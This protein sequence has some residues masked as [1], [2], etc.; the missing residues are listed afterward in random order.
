MEVIHGCPLLTDGKKHFA[1]L[2]T[3]DGVHIGHEKIIRTMVADA[4]GER[5]KSL[6]ITFSNHPRNFLK[7]EKPIKLLTSAMAKQKYIGRLGV[8]L[9]ALLEF[10]RRLADMDP[11]TFVRDI[12]VSCYK[13]SHIYV[14][15][16]YTFGFK[17]EGT[18]QLLKEFGEMF[19]FKV[20]VMPPIC[21]RGDP[22]SSSSIRG[23][24]ASGQIE[25]ASEY[26]GRFPEFTAEV[27]HG[28]KIGR[29]IGFPTANLL[30]ESD[31]QLPLPGAYFGEAEVENQLYDAVVNIG[32]RPTLG[33]TEISFEAHLLDFD[34]C[35][36]GEYITVRLKKRLRDEI[37]FDSIQEL[38]RQIA[39]DLEAVSS[40]RSS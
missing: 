8:D 20:V 26:L 32:L 21:F 33:G 22:V 5:G 1:A 30:I 7:P 36:Y 17:G 19:G 4:E 25:L 11:L 6:V 3:F 38:G 2:G 15:F 29:S 12:L 37:K 27:V 39:E 23:L 13:V 24:M 16:N 28:N 34:N 10:N 40:L 31:L 14:G 18:P 9:F 35:L